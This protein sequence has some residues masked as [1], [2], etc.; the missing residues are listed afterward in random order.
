MVIIETYH[1]QERVNQRATWKPP[2]K[3]RRQFIECVKLIK[4][5]KIHPKKGASQNTHTIE[6]A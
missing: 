4:K 2:D 1:F 6:Y 5:K 3:I